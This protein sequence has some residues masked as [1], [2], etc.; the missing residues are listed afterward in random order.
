MDPTWELA[1]D[2]RFSRP[3]VEMLI[4]N[5][6]VPAACFSLP[7]TSRQ[8]LHQLDTA[9]LIIL[10]LC[11][12]MTLLSVVIY[13]EE[14]SYLFRKIRCPI[15]MKTLCWSSSAPTVVSVV[16][17][18]GLWFPRSMMVVEMATTAYF[19]VCFYLLMLVM[20]EGFGG[21]EALLSTLKDVP[22]VVSTGPCCCCC[23]CLPRI[24]MS[25]IKLKLMILGTFQ[26]ALFKAVAVFL[27]LILATDG[28]YNPADI[29]AESVSLWINTLVGVS[30][31][32]GLWGL[33][34]L[35]RQA[36]L[37]LAE[38]N[39]QAKF[40]CFQILLLLTALQPAIFSILANNGS[41]ACSPPFS[42][43]A[44]SQRKYGDERAAHMLPAKPFH[45][46]P[47]HGGWALWL[48]AA[49]KYPSPVPEMNVQLLIPQ[50]FILAVLT[51]MYYRKQ[52]DKPGY[53]PVGFAATGADAKA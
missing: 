17:C 10:G 36:R 49:S 19:A 40:T 25:R 11:T 46:V 31:L 5:F 2:P 4:R 39:M 41:I 37:H 9:Q 53:Q 34:I 15:K 47:W 27:G 52:D 44:R 7:P 16:S 26:Y 18:F 50:T 32:F 38:Q 42:S 24:T 48:R 30:A 45:H 20:V 23:P 29:S 8:L 12:I 14:V 21:K 43:K 1:D 6:S 22:M 28:N 35:F 51:R 3:L 13:V 33:G